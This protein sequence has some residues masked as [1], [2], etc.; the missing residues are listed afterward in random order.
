MIQSVRRFLL[1]FLLG[2]PVLPLVAG[3]ADPFEGTWE[4]D[5]ARSNFKPGPPGFKS[6][7]RVMAR[8][9][10]GIHMT[11]D[12]VAAND[13]KLSGSGT[14]RADGTDYSFAGI[15]GFDSIAMTQTSVLLQE[16]VAKLQGRPTMRISFAL[17]SDHRELTVRA[18][19]VEGAARPF[20]NTLVFNRK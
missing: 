12:G 5:L 15:P 10:D 1:A 11:V 2:L 14:Y 16:G 6:Q 19:A 7:T 18:T 13:A 17:S 4:L 3:A 20:D 8:V 9:P